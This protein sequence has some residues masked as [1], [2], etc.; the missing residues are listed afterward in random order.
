MVEEFVVPV[1]EDPVV[2]V[3]AVPGG[4]VGGIDEDAPEEVEKV[5]G[6]FVKVVFV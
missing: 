5:V 2:V 6:N 1:D 4:V 3:A